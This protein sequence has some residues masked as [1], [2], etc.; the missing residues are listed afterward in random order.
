MWINITPFFICRK[1]LFFLLIIC[2]AMTAVSVLTSRQR[3]LTEMVYDM[4]FNFA[5]S[6]ILSPHPSNSFKS[7]ASFRQSSCLL[8]SK[9]S[10]YFY[11]P[12]D[13]EP[14]SV[15]LDEFVKDS[16]KSAIE[17]SPYLTDDP[18]T[19]CLYVVLIGDM[20][21][22]VIHSTDLQKYL[23]SLSFWNGTGQNHL[24]LYL[25]HR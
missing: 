10:V 21:A 4:P 19:A 20:K 1:R 8:S 5:S 13:Y 25:S 24:L 22:G 3:L 11:N 18:H 14:V 9:F 12:D 2:A 16:V 7:D 6:S 17:T 23:N 15:H